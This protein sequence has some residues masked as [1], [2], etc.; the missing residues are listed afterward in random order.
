MEILELK[1]ITEI[2]N[3]MDGFNN[4]FDT[5]EERTGEMSDKSKG[6]NAE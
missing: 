4:K 3:S 1:K 2:N 5:N 6:N